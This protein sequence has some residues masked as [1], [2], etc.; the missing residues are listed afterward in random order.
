MR[1]RRGRRDERRLCGVAGAIQEDAP[2]AQGD[3]GR[4]RAVI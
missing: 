2:V 1:D 3:S 4:Q